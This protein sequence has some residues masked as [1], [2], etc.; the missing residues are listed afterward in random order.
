MTWRNSNINNSAKPSK[1]N[2]MPQCFV[3][4]YN[5]LINIKKFRTST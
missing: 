3:N 2:S 5:I 1:I 4:C